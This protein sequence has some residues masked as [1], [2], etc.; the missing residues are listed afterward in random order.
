MHSITGLNRIHFLA[1]SGSESHHQLQPR[2][3]QTASHSRCQTGGQVGGSV[4]R[5]AISRFTSCASSCPSLSRSCPPTRPS[6]SACC[7][8]LSSTGSHHGG[9]SHLWHHPSS[10]C[11]LGHLGESYPT[12]DY[13]S[14]CPSPSHSRSCCSRSHST[15]S[16]CGQSG[17]PQ[18]LAQLT[19]AEG[20]TGP[21]PAAVPCYEPAS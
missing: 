2:P 3:A 18:L 19:A 14:R 21:G 4:G 20:L 17:T 9:T 12:K 10:H 11:Q 5:P 16:G 13:P 1:H 6:C 15:G 8:L 7:R